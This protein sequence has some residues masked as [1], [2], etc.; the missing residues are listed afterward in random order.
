MNNFKKRLP[1]QVTTNFQDTSD[2]VGTYYL[3]IVK[4]NDS[5]SEVA[6]RYSVEEEIIRNYNQDK[7]LEAGSVLIIPY[8]P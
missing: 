4:E 5:Y 6:T 3:Y 7:A 8:V 2:S 1:K